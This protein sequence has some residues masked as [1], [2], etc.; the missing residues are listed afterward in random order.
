MDFELTEY[1]RSTVIYTSGRIDSYTAPEVE[2][3]LNQ[4]IEKGQYNI[5]M[6]MR[7]VNFISSAGWWALIR[8]QK[9]VKKMNRGELVLVHLDE[10]IQESMD[11]VGITPY[12]S[13]Y[14]DMTE[15]VGSF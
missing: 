11:L 2:E 5:I 14:D 4:L 1:K 8:V 6:D 13:I 10:R 15:A 3:A 12:F 9:E 7:D